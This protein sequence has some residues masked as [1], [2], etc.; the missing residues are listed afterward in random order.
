MIRMI[1]FLKKRIRLMVPDKNN[2]IAF[3]YNF[4]IKDF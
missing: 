2:R 3:S 4:N 1:F